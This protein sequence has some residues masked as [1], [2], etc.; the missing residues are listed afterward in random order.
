MSR[1]AILVVDS[2]HA[3]LQ[4]T[5]QALARRVRADYLVVSAPAAPLGLQVL[6]DLASKEADVALVAAALR[7]TEG[8]GMSPPAGTFPSP[9]GP[10]SGRPC[11]W[12]PVCRVSSPSGMDV[13]A[14]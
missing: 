10:L 3:E 7:M 9:I 6:A 5:V 12:K 2:D 8:V 4:R 13:A 14:Q 1:P 11:C